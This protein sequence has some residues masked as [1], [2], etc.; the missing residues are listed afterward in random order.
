MNSIQGHSLTVPEG[1]AITIRQE[2]P[3]PFVVTNDDGSSMLRLE[4]DGTVS[5]DLADRYP[6]AVPALK[7]L[8]ER[9]K[10]IM[11]RPSWG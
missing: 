4:A 11:S 10:T 7:E 2:L 1:H 8:G 3:A 5:G 6:E 9:I